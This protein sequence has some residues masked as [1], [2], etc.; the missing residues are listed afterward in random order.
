MKN[1]NNHLFLGTVRRAMMLAAFLCALAPITTL[2]CGIAFEARIPSEQALIS[3]ADGRQEIITSV[4]LQSEGENA[5]VIFPVPGVPDV[6]VIQ[7]DQLFRYLEEVTSPAIRVEERLIWNSD[8]GSSAMPAG[9]VDVL[10]RE[11]IDGYDIARLAADDPGALQQWLDENG[12]TVPDAARPIL[13][14]YIDEGWKFV[15]IKLAGEGVDGQLKPIRMS[16][17]SRDIV[18]PMRLGAL[19]DRPVD[20]QLY[21]LAQHRV[22]I[23]GMDTEYA[24]PVDQLDQAPPDELA[25]HFRAPYLTKMR[26]ERIDPTSLT[27]DFVAQQAP[28]NDPFR[29]EV[30]HV[31]YVNGWDRFAIPIILLIAIVLLNVFVI[32]FALG[33][34]RRLRALSGPPDDQQP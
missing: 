29:K 22:M 12:Y 28:T 3:F 16:F 31:Q 32:A 10:G 9:G 6:D 27:A 8:E 11:V 26:N 21:I 30:V 19:S 4:H 23:N 20:A 15:A 1:M 25:T 34:R 33:V 14:S 5:A 7:S 17:E 24:G 18:Y 2:A 13:Q